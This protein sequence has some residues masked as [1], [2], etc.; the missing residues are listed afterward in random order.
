M[1]VS[2]TVSACQL[3]RRNGHRLRPATPMCGAQGANAT[4]MAVR[5]VCAWSP[6]QKPRT[7]FRRT[8]IRG[9]FKSNFNK[10]NPNRRKGRYFKVRVMSSLPVGQL[11]TAV[12][13]SAP[14]RSRGPAVFPDVTTRLLLANPE[15]HRQSGV[16]P[17]ARSTCRRRPWA[18]ES[19]RRP[20]RRPVSHMENRS[21]LAPVSLAGQT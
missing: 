19:G 11:H 12:V 4:S 6:M 10:S 15:V 5:Q 2:G 7:P 16:R 8:G 17:R 3:D 1:R 18:Y 9:L 13:C 21:P 20:F 14:E